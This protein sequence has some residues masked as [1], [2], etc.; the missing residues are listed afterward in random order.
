MYTCSLVCIS[1]G[2]KKEGTKINLGSEGLP[3][4]KPTE[5]DKVP[6]Y[7]CHLG[8]RPF[9]VFFPRE[10]LKVQNCKSR[11][12]LKLRYGSLITFS[13]ASD[14]VWLNRS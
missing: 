1:S 3:K 14:K 9:E 7:L 4:I 5:L 13:Q 8:S 12:W 6:K 11:L 2:S 10:S